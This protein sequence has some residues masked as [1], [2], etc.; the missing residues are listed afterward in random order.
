MCG[1]AGI[2]DFKGPVSQECLDFFTDALAHRGPDGRGTLLDGP[3]GL[4]HRRLAI[5]DISDAGR[6]PLR[7]EAPDGR[8]LWTVFNGEI[9]NFLELKS[10]LEALGHRF[11][12]KTDTEIIPAAY[13]QWGADC[14]LR[15][16]G[17]WAF[18][19]YD[20]RDR[21]LFLSRDRFG[22]KP[23]Y[24]LIQDGMLAFASEIKAFTCLEGYSPALDDAVVPI[25]VKNP[26]AYEG[27]TVDTLMR[28]VRRLPPG[29]LLQL[30]P[31][32]RCVVR[33]WW[34]TA[35][36]IPKMPATY[37]E[38][39]EG[40]RELFL[41]AVRIRLRSDVPVG[42]CLSGGVDSS[43]VASAMAWLNRHVDRDGLNRCAKDW[44][45]A[46][47][48]A[49]PGTV[50]DERE[51]ADEVVRHVGAKPHYWNFD[52]NEAIEHI[53]DTVWS[54]E[55]IYNGV[56]VPPWC[57]YMEMRRQNVVVSIDGHGGD[58]LLAGYPW[59]LDCTMGK[60][61]NVLYNEFHSLVL[62]AILRNYDRC[63]MAHGVEVRMPIMDW[64]LVTYSFGLP[65]SAKIGGGFTKRVFRDAMAG[66]MPEKNRLRRSKIGFNSPMI[67]WLNG[68]LVPFVK[69]IT[70]SKQF[71][72]S[73]HWNGPAL[74]QRA[75]GLS[76]AKAWTMGHWGESLYL[77]TVINIVL[78]Q[79]LFVT[80]EIDLAK[81]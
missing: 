80:R 38:Q 61:N 1:I 13:C 36:H 65:A 52:S 19:L 73:P 58:E 51:Y 67:E 23:L 44:Q 48:A 45:R 5:L 27:R 15:F 77:W 11:H 50:L 17:M 66:I 25:V 60:L 46:F 26:A 79:M 37:A 2:Y 74:R 6:N 53:I 30:G 10:E 57:L 63:S 32:G 81:G 16:N 4:G 42:T 34:E 35:D 68:G 72:D 22:I 56:A 29:H 21:S 69:K 71:L 20:P 8:I 70:A 40:F 55:E 76:E 47:I 12:T 28:G 49:F 9:Y 75:V 3:V 14:L 18:A 7:Y 64:R 62:P 43:A 41:D 31:D 78:W 33:R 24:Y 39:V 54:M 59:Y